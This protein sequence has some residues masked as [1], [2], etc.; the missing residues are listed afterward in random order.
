MKHD[1]FV[2]GGT[3]YLGSRLIPLLQQRGHHVAAVARNGSEYKLPDGIQKIV[4]DPL[5]L[6]AYTKAVRGADTFVHLIGGARPSPS[7]ARQFRDIDLVSVQVATHA[8]LEA[9]V[10][11]FVYVS[12][13]QPALIRRDYIAARA[14]CETILHASGLG[15]TF[16]RPWYVV[17]PGR[18]WPCALLPLYWVGACLPATRASAKRLGLVSLAQMLKALVWAVENPPQDVQ[19]IEV[20]R[21]RVVARMVSPA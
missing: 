2:T 21:I 7:K 15:A 19:I 14:E 18:R 8:A 12:V 1:V 11:H 20:P 13:A 4:A 17:G 9:G 5:R 16:V 10:K 3:G 6:R